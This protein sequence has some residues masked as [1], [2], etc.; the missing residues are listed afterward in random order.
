MMKR[1]DFEREVRAAA[2]AYDGPKEGVLAGLAFWSELKQKRPDG[3]RI[4]RICYVGPRAFCRARGCSRSRDRRP[5]SLSPR[6]PA[7]GALRPA[8]WRGVEIS[9]NS[10]DFESFQRSN[11]YIPN[12]RISVKPLH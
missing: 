12:E 6:R 10:C 9:T 3:L 8:H 1:V 2:L 7:I 11:H 4:L 5:G